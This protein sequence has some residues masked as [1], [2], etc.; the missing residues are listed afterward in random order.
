[1]DVENTDLGSESVVTDTSSEGEGSSA[2]ES[3]DEGASA[4]AESS[5]GE[6]EGTEETES[7]ADPAAPQGEVDAEGQPVFK[8]NTKMKILDKEVEIPKN[9]QRFMTDKASE[10]EIRDL[11]SFAEGAKHLKLKNAEISQK[12]TEKSHEMQRFQAGVDE[13]RNVYTSAVQTGNWHKLDTFFEKL[14]IPQ[15][16]IMTWALE[17]AKLAQMEPAQRA[18]VENQ[19]AADKQA[20]M[21]RAQQG[22]RD[23]QNAQLMRELKQV[24]IEQTLARPEI[25]AMAS[26][27]EGRTGQPGSF[28]AMMNRYGQLAWMQSNGKTNLTPPQVVA[29]MAK[30]FGLTGKVAAAKPGPATPGGSNVPG[31]KIVQRST[32]T[33]PNM[34]GRAGAS[35]LKNKPKSIADLQALY[36]AKVESGN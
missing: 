26:E 1:M 7:E 19:I 16:H 13:L 18:A 34:Q 22:S 14:Q 11:Y 8:P 32:N 36:K 6:T 2:S 27:Y 30:D 23:S 10:K 12:F 9:L 3:S 29:Q 5:P 17:K 35:P 4:A 33:I 25:A 31:K 24:Q 20:E 28:K 15:D 21:M